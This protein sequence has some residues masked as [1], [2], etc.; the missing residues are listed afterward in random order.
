VFCS[1]LAV[2]ALVYLWQPLPGVVWSLPR[3][4]GP[5]VSALGVLGLGLAGLASMAIDGLDLIG[6]RAPLRA[7]RGRPQ[8]DPPFV[9]PLVYRYVRHP[10]QLGV[11]VMLWGTGTMSADRLLMALC[12]TGYVL[13]ALPLEERDLVEQYGEAYRRYRELVPRLLPRLRLRGHPQPPLD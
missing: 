5:L 1:A 11:L 13:V 7:L 8:L 9:T 4:W 2:L 10:I 3:P 12:A 6:L